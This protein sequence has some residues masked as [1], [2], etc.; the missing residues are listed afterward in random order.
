MSSHHSG[1]DLQAT[2]EV[3][4]D[5]KAPFQLGGPTGEVAG[6]EA[7]HE[8]ATLASAFSTGIASMPVLLVFIIR[9]ARF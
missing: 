1:R 5:G 6:E 8:V 9:G 4:M 2:D 3:A 7:S